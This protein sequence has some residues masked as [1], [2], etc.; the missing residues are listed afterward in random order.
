MEEKIERN[1]SKNIRLGTILGYISLVLSIVSGLLYTPWI[2]ETIGKESYGIYTLTSSLVNLFLVDFGLSTTIN[3]FLA[4]YRAAKD[5]KSISNFLTLAYRLF[6]FIDAFLVLIFTIIFFFVDKIYVGLN[7]EQLSEFKNVYLVAAIFSVFSFP[8]TIFSGVIQSYEKFVALKIIDILHRVVFI[9][10]SALALIFG[11]GLMGLVFANFGS[12]FLCH[13]FRYIY[14]RFAIKAKASFS[15]KPSKDFVKKVFFYSGWAAVQ[16]ITSRLIFNI[17]PSILG[18]VSGAENIATFGFISQLE[19]YVYMFGNVMG[20][21]FL[22][23]IARLK[24]EKDTREELDKMAIWVGKIQ[25]FFVGLVFAGFVSCGID[26][27]TLWLKDSAT[28]DIYI[29]TIIIIAYQLVFVP[30][31]IYYSEMFLAN[32]I[33]Y[34]AIGSL[35]KAVLNCGLSVLLGYFYGA[36]GAAI[37]VGVSRVFELVYINVAF[38]KCLEAPLGKFYKGVYLRTVPALILSIGIGL[39]LEMTLP[40][41]T[42]FRL[43]LSGISCVIVFVLTYMFFGF[44]KEEKNG[45]LNM[46]K[47][48]QTAKKA[49]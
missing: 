47:K 21:F 16:S 37:S 27:T 29:G 13:L 18:I 28:L 4:K 44:T 20:G 30:E 11:W 38:K 48:K 7:P 39:T 35:I 6:F 43:L 25:F 34:L 23:K 14:M 12:A 9:V 49:K 45:L 24:K 17:M 40:I 31:A 22:P 10:T 32:K 1:S 2:K 41:S 33:K 42:L 3:T 15:Y 8:C 26:F 46:I 5:E 19:G 36:L